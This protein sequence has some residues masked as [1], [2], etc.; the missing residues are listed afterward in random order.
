MNT[1]A[2]N[3]ASLMAFASDRSPRSMFFVVKDTP[4]PLA[5]PRMTGGGRVWDSQKHQKLIIGLS[6]TNQ[7]NGLPLFEGALEV[8]ITFY[9][10]MPKRINEIRRAAMRNT[11]HIFKPDI[12]NCIK[13]YLDCAS[14]GILFED[15]AIIATIHSKKLYDDVPRTE[16]VITE[17]S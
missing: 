12:D 11:P 1:K 5:R 4:I 8:D 9:F 13:M 2:T 7:L 14:N 10:P 17:I 3:N 15:D 16:I 6:L